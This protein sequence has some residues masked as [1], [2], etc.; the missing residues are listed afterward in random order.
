MVI[1]AAQQGM[2]LG[3]AAMAALPG[4]I[5]EH[6]PGVTALVLTVNCLK[7]V[8][9]AVYLKAGFQDAGEIYHGGRSGPQHVLRLPLPATAAHP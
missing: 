2:G 1:D 8:A 7:P 3:K 9:R 4:L 6:H 5:A